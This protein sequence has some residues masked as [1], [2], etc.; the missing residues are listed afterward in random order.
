MDSDAPALH[1]IQHIRDESHRF[2]IAG[3]RN[4]RQKQRTQSLL[5]EIN[6]SVLSVG[7]HY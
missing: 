1:L 4:K 2:A 5:E 6:E 3:H 7:K